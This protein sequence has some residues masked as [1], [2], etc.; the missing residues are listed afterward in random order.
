MENPTIE[1][2]TKCF[3]QWTFNGIRSNGNADIPDEMISYVAKI[4]RAR[5]SWVGSCIM[6][7][8]TSIKMDNF[9]YLIIDLM[10]GSNPGIALVMQYYLLEELA[11]Q[12]GGKLKLPL[13]ITAIDFAN[14]F[15]IFYQCG[16][17]KEH[18]DMWIKIWDRQKTDNGKNK[19]DGI[20]YWMELFDVPTF[21][22]ADNQSD[23]D[24]F[25]SAT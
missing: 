6:Q 17:S 4:I 19:V 14:I 16:E 24:A 22:H 1:L 20:K 12:R 5:M 18:E 10:S 11:K 23:N 2:I 15:P 25:A 7:D 13:N 8:P 9:G 21:D 3:V